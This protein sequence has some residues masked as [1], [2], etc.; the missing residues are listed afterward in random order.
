MNSALSS[1]PRLNTRRHFL[2]TLP[3]IGWAAAHAADELPLQDIVF[4][5]CLDTHDHPMLDRT[6]TLPRDLFIFM[7]DNIY[8]DKG[9]IPMM[10][11]KYALLKN[12]RFFKGLQNKP[13]LATWDDH[14]FGENDGGGSY[15]QKKEAHVEFWNW[16]DEPASSPRR[17]QEGV[18]HARTFG[19]AGKRV[20][21]VM[22]DT[23]YFRSPLKKVP[24]DK[25]LLGG[26]Y[27]PTDDTAAT[28]LGAEQWSWL[29]QVLQQ[30]AELRL[31][32][33][34]IQ[35]APEVHGGECWANMPHEQQKLLKLL[36]GQTAVVLSG[37]R[38]WCEFS[39][40]GVFD[41]TTSSMTQK[42]PRGTPTPNKYRCMPQT[43][44][45]PNVGHL[46]IDWDAATITVKVFGEDGGTK[47][48]QTLPFRE[49]LIS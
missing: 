28:M 32:V 23:R 13:I 11:E 42:H 36:R 21:V 3:A 15:P 17:Q 9:G 39:H 14:D 47:I 12:S 2:A 20:Q 37:D 40:N 49:L 27:V 16:L 48:A 33:S 10:Q 7:G 31:I 45:L 22:L 44:H 38:H 25:A 46:R 41:F 30:P 6:L 29:A 34:S 35:F 5:S 8:A 18:Y 1:M 19:P 4:G 24:K 26:S 43:Y